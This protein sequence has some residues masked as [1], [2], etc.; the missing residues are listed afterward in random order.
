MGIKLKLNKFI[1]IIFSVAVIICILSAIAS[2]SVCAKDDIDSGIKA[3]LQIYKN[4]NA[5]ISLNWQESFENE[6]GFGAFWLNVGGE[7]KSASIGDEQGDFSLVKSGK[8]LENERSFHAEQGDN[9]VFIKYSQDSDTHN[10]HLSAEIDGFVSSYDDYDGFD[11]SIEGD[12]VLKDIKSASVTVSLNNGGFIEDNSNFWLIGF[13][14]ETK[15]QNGSA[16]ISSSSSKADALR[17]ICGMNKNLI[18]P[19][20]MTNQKLTDIVELALDST[21]DERFDIAVFAAGAFAAAVLIAIGLFT[22]FV[23]ATK[24]KRFKD[25]TIEYA[26]LPGKHQLDSSLWI[27]KSFKV[28]DSFI[29]DKTM[30]TVLMYNMVLSGSVEIED[31]KLKLKSVPENQTTK[32]LYEL[33]GSLSN[34][35]EIVASTVDNSL[36]IDAS[37]LANAVLGVY[38]QGVN[39]LKSK[40]CFVGVA[41]GSLKN[42]TDVGK[43]ELSALIG[44]CKYLTSNQLSVVDENAD[45]FSV[46]ALLFGLDDA[47]SDE[48][49]QKIASV[50]AFVEASF[51]NALSS[52]Q[53]KQMTKNNVI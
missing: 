41:S 9:G 5:L 14:G 20:E 50:S 16:I 3:D 17:I 36:K 4:G 53:Y 21:N 38:Q 51:E 46:Y 18:M 35:G 39:K 8:T 47:Q 34:W 37:P 29:D 10:M 1:R 2:I 24:M 27:C 42:L 48:N 15:Y 52:K 43:A 44:L 6:Q 19:K 28:S 22:Y 32:Q 40:G 49:R 23:K 33:F 26:H 45:D 11:F 7:L 25:K 12:S 30:L 13:E 31:N